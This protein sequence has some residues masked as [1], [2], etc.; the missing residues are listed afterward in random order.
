MKR[1]KKILYLTTMALVILTIGYFV[2]SYTQ[3]NSNIKQEVFMHEFYR[4]KANNGFVSFGT[5]K[6]TVICY[7]DNYYFIDK[8]TYDKG[9]F[10]LENRDNEEIYKIG[11]IDKDTIYLSDFNTYFY[12]IKL[13][14]EA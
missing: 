11:V 12:N 4:T 13:F 7:E 10:T 1:L 6:N 2:F 3:I 5:F 14:N 8:V 9:I